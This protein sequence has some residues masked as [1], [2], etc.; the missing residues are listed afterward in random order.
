MINV[1]IHFEHKIFKYQMPPGLTIGQ[2]LIVFR[3]RL[4]LTSKHAIFMFRENSLLLCSRSLIDYATN[5]T[6][7]V[8]CKKENTFG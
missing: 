8:C 7:E 6:L 2:L 1:I 3:K 5:D 4:S